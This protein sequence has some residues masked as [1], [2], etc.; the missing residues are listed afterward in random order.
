MYYEHISSRSAA[1]NTLVWYTTRKKEK[2]AVA[3][4]E[5]AEQIRTPCMLPE[6]QY[7]QRLSKVE[8]PSP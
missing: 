6:D 1:L 8:P 2:A 3:L 5:I 4:S 7:L